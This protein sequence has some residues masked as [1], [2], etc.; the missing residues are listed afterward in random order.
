MDYPSAGF[1]RIA[2]AVFEMQQRLQALQEENRQL[3]EALAALRRGVGI[4]LVIE[5]HFY[6]LVT[7]VPSPDRRRPSF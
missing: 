3:H 1:E 6:P 2:E 7:G 5:G 4:T